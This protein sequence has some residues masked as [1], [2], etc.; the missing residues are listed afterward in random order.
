MAHRRRPDRYLV[1]IWL[2]FAVAITL[3]I[4]S[5]IWFVQGLLDLVG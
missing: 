1:G 4:A 3:F 5:T 2:F